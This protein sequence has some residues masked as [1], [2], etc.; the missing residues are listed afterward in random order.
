M[1]STESSARRI[2]SASQ[3]TEA[4]PELTPELVQRVLSELARAYRHTRYDSEVVE[5]HLGT[6]GCALVAARVAQGLHRRDASEVLT[7]FRAQAQAAMTA[8]DRI[9]GDCLVAAQLDGIGRAFETRAIDALNEEPREAAYQR[10]TELA[11]S[12]GKARNVQFAALI[13]TL[14][15]DLAWLE[16]MPGSGLEASAEEC[17]RDFALELGAGA[18]RFL[19]AL[20]AFV[21]AGDDASPKYSADG[22]Q[23]APRPANTNG[24]RARTRS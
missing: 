17:A 6:D 20:R 21:G 14:A 18:P 23:R 4:V 10:I 24:G 13:A 3:P 15:G 9:V 1:R 11:R 22:A 12:G 5:R 2:P 8:R 7:F 16:A 19:D